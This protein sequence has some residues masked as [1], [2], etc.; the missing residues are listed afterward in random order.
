MTVC[1]ARMLH[2]RKFFA[3]HS[4]LRRGV[5]VT[6]FSVEL[7]RDLLTY[8]EAARRLVKGRLL[9]GR[10]VLGRPVWRYWLALS[11]LLS[12]DLHDMLDHGLRYVI[13]HLHLQI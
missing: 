6:L 3:A 1:L 8:P 10:E 7:V 12:W 9:Y 4:L 11:H 2:C 5:G 13:M